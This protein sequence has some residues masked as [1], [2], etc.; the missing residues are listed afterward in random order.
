MTGGMEE[1]FTGRWLG[2]EGDYV[3]SSGREAWRQEKSNLVRARREMPPSSV[4][5]DPRTE[6]PLSPRIEQCS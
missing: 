6:L 1:G 2:A 4:S 5:G 3:F